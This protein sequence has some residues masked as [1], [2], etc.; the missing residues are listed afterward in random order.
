M[1]VDGWVCVCGEQMKDLTVFIHEACSLTHMQLRV[2]EQIC[3]TGKLRLCQGLVR[4]SMNNCQSVSE[5]ENKYGY[6]RE[7]E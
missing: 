3:G 6:Y 5:T 7:R 2:N 1:C 4:V